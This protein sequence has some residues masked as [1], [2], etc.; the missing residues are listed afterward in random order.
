MLPFGEGPFALVT[1][2]LAIYNVSAQ[3]RKAA[4]AE[5]ARVCPPGRRMIILEL[6]GYAAGYEEALRHVRGW[7]NVEV[8]M[9]DRK[10]TRLN[11]SHSGESR[12]PSSA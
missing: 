7:K 12:M 10:S 8:S 4:N 11:S 5:L 2:R 9:E 3:R 6:M 1:S